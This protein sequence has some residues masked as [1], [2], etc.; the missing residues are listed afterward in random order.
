M[1]NAGAF[2][3]L[4]KKNISYSIVC[5]TLTY[6]LL[7][8]GVVYSGIY[9][10]RL[11]LYVGALNVFSAITFYF[12]DPIYRVSFWRSLFVLFI[13]LLSLLFLM[14]SS[15]V[16]MYALDKIEGA[17]ISTVLIS[18]LVACSVARLGEEKFIKYFMFVS[19]G[20]LILTFIYRLA[21]ELPG[22]EGRFFINGPIVFGWLMGFNFVCGLL[23]Y[24]KSRES[25]YLFLSSVFLL[26]VFWSQ[27]KGPF[28]AVFT[29]MVFV[30]LRLFGWGTFFKGLVY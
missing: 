20:F 17:V 7:A 23:A 4:A 18:S 22:R 15:L 24:S 27:S 25:V 1:G 9:S 10:E 21:L 8:T 16:T 28:V 29:V 13:L 5:V 26:A 11:Y 30:I 2:S 19:L 14:L 3:V 12:L 6:F